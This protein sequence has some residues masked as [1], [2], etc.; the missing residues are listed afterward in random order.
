MPE[1]RSLVVDTDEDIGDVLLSSFFVLCCRC[2]ADVDRRKSVVADCTS[3]RSRLRSTASSYFS[4]TALPF[5]SECV[6]EIPPDLRLRARPVP[7]FCYIRQELGVVADRRVGNL[8]PPVTRP[9][10]YRDFSRC[11]I[12]ADDFDT[13]HHGVERRE[14]LLAI[15]D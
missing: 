7:Q 2:L 13:P 6:N 10:R 3:A 1:P 12:F 11:S 8:E 9:E 14:T 15:D 5:I 4:S